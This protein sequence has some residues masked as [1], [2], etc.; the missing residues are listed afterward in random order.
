M[1]LIGIFCLVLASFMWL[2]QAV[3][4]FTAK[5]ERND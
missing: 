2:E 4:E 3:A 1:Y 5:G